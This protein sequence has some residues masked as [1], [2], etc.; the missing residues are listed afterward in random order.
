MRKEFY[1]THAHLY[2]RDFVN[3][4]PDVISRARRLGVTKIIL[5]NIDLKTIEDMLGL[6]DF[7]PNMC[8][9]SLGLH[10]SSV[11]QNYREDLEKISEYF[12]QRDFVAIGETGIDLYWDKS[13]EKEQIES[14]KIQLGWAKEKNLPIIIHTRK[15][16]DLVIKTVQEAG[17]GIRGIF[18]CF[19]GSLEEAKKIIS[20]GNF[21]M[22]LGGVVTFKNSGVQ[23][24]VE[25]IPLEHFVL[26]TD[27]PY[28]APVPY[29]GKR[30]E[31]SYIVKVAEKIAEIKNC[32]LEEVAEKTFKNAEEIFK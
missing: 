4:Y 9:P 15:S 17:D 5:P 20:L 7:Y 21:K 6:S 1:D 32:S 10:P 3:E 2:S 24:V 30:N 31:S 29:R 27:A 22:G 13:F 18:H 28:L 26:E 11:T 14:F 23:E 16:F 8:F 25:K 12:N 19:S